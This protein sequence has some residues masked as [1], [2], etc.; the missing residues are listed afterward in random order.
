MR[1][2]RRNIPLA[3]AFGATLLIAGC[4]SLPSLPRIDLSGWFNGN[5]GE[6]KT[7]SL[8]VVERA[9]D[10]TF[11]F[12]KLILTGSNVDAGSN[13]ITLHLAGPIDSSL[14]ADI[15]RSA[16]DWIAGAQANG[17]TATIVAKK[18]VDFSTT[19]ISDGFDLTL[20]PRIP[21]APT[22]APTTPVETDPLR[23]AEPNANASG[24]VDGL[25]R[26]GMLMGFGVDDPASPSTA[27]GL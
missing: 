9:P 13:E 23:G 14:I 8:D 5:H 3:A 16:P 27:N 12:H 11:R 17:D 24:E 10:L 21:G 4:D 6:E 7:A 19:R 15:Q 1:P 26:Q 2:Y 22:A 18:D 25:Q 20:K